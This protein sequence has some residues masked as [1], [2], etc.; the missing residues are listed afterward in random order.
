MG[1]WGFARAGRRDRDGVVVAGGVD[2]HGLMGRVPS[3]A[4]GREW[5]CGALRCW[6]LGHGVH[7]QLCGL[8]QLMHCST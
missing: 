7:G 8:S 1:V 2:R 4:G 5:R 3:C 6:C